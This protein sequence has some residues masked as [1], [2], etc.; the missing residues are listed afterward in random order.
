MKANAP[1]KST[2]TIATVLAILAVLLVILGRGI[3]TIPFLT[4]N[5]FWILLIGFCLLLL[6]CFMKKL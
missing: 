2:I 5:A 6:G 3:L 1:T 4:V